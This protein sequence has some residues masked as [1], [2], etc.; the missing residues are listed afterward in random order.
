MICLI[1]FHFTSVS[2]LHRG[3]WFSS[4]CASIS[5]CSSSIVRFLFL[6]TL[7]FLFLTPMDLIAVANPHPWISCFLYI[8]IFGP[9]WLITMRWQRH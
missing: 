7:S 9:E 1:T 3:D 8:Y 5:L 6:S 2:L 4:C